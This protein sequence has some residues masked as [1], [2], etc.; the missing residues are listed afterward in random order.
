V[1]TTF[2]CEN[3]C[4]E[5]GRTDSAQLS[6]ASPRKVKFPHIVRFRTLTATI[7]GRTAN[8]PFYRLA[9]KVAG[10]RLVRSFQKFTEAKSEAEN[11]LRE[12]SKGNQSAGLNAKE[13]ADALAIREAVQVFYRDTGRKVSALQAV[14]GYLTALRVLPVD[15]SPEEACRKFCQTIAAV[16]RKP[17]AAA[18]TE[19]CEARKPK[20]VSKDGK[21]SALNPVYV[22]DTA[23]MLTEF[24]TA[25]TALD[26]CDVTKQHVDLFM[27]ARGKLSPKSRNHIRATLKMFLGW[28]V[29][30]DF[31]SANHRLLESDGLRKE[32]ADTGDVEFYSPQELR[33]MLENATKEMRVII[34]LQAFGGLRLQEALRLDWRD[35]FTIPGHV[36][37]SSAKS[38]TRSRRLVEINA[39]LESWLAEFR[40]SE[41]NVTAMTL[42][43]YTW[44]LIQLRK[45]LE[46]PSKKNGLRHGF[47]S[48]H[49][50]IHQNEG[51]T[52]AQ[53]GT[54]PAMLYRHYRGLMPK[55]QAEKWFAVRPA[56][57]AKNIIQLPAKLAAS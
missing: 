4:F 14:N 53:A 23:R 1:G 51:M 39:T 6:T 47:L 32:E 12:L 37:I 48:A 8:Y 46:I 26:V 33:A 29:R 22:A 49:F 52:A 28:C 18:V 27:A 50:A 34:A 16:Q 45:R 31:L 42:D 25:N 15:V 41:G 21:R 17:L 56:K 19:F 13:S 7:Y 36:E 54:S 43:A 20:A 35:V 5:N 3:E 55:A 11:K 24:S 57:S 38:K 10:K 30:R 9:V 40:G 44:Q 2:H